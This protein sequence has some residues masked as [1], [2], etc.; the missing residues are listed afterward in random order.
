[1]E[2]DIRILVGAENA[3][4]GD[5][6]P[7]VDATECRHRL[8]R[9][10]VYGFCIRDVGRHR[11]GAAATSLAFPGDLGQ[12]IAPASRQDDVSPPPREGQG[13]GAADPA[14][15]SCDDDRRSFDRAGHT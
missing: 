5:V 4:A 9:Q 11:Y 6:D 2:R 1:M 13:R 15:G 14:R 3:R 7:C 10:A 12:E 8:A